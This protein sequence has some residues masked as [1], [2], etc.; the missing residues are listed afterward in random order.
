[1]ELEVQ[2]QENKKKEQEKNK[3]KEKEGKEKKKKGEKT[4]KGVRHPLE[5]WT[6][7]TGDGVSENSQREAD[8]GGSGP[9]AR[10]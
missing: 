1:M 7:G 8:L 9:D 10:R 3:E 2:V 4:K 6:N 5:P